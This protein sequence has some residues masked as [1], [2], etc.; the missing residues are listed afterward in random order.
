MAL[1]Y[2]HWVQG[3][4]EATRPRTHP[5]SHEAVS[6]RIGAEVANENES[7]HDEAALVGLAA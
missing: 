6:G 7:A 2:L 4:A 1:P 5:A 3:V